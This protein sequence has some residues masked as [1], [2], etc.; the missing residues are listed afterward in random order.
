[1]HAPQAAAEGRRRRT[2]D[3]RERNAAPAEPGTTG[4]NGERSDAT[5]DERQRGRR[6]RERRTQRAQGAEGG[7]GLLRFAPELELILDLVRRDLAGDPAPDGAVE[8]FRVRG[9]V[10]G[11]ACEH[12]PCDLRTAGPLSVRVLVGHAAHDTTHAD[13]SRPRG[14]VVRSADARREQPAVGAVRLVNLPAGWE[15]CGAPGSAQSVPTLAC[16]AALAGHPPLIRYIY[17]GR[18]RYTDEQ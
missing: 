9:A 11:A 10:K 15:R 7:A 14:S 3:H 1:M 2:A 16:A 4:A 18:P 6:E 17:G 13:L 12:L 8:P 5:E